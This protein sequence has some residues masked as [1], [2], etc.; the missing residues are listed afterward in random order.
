MK[1]RFGA[2]RGK[3]RTAIALA[4]VVTSALSGSV[5]ALADGNSIGSDHWGVITRNT[6][7]SPVAALRDGPFVTG[8]GSRPPYGNGS[9]GIEVANNSTTLPTPSEKVDFGNEVDFYGNRVRDL[10][11]LGFHVF[12]TGENVNYA[13]DRNLPNIRIEAN[14]NLA[15]HPGDTYTTLVWLPP[16]VPTDRLN[17]WS[18]FLDATVLGGQWFLSGNELSPRCTQASPCDFTTL[19]NGLPQA[20]IYSVAVGKGR[21]NLWVG[22]VDGLRINK[23]VY[24]FEA[25][26]VR[27]RR[28]S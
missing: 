19:K 9:L 3:I 5:S 8:I 12:Q 21:D 16:A 15:S 23:Y 1:V 24:D 13:N 20:T 17:R 10:T 6:I 14:P 7:G 22:A 2:S 28:V 27:A 4:T 25:D 11:H 26:G 18:K